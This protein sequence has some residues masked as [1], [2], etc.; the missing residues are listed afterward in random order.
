MDCKQII[1]IGMHH[2]GTSI[3]SRMTMNMGIYGG[4]I[5]TDFILSEQN[6]L[7]F[8]ERIDVVNENQE[9]FE[10]FEWR[11][12][13][14]SG[15][16]ERRHSGLPYWSGVTYKPNVGIP[17]HLRPSVQ[18]II[19]KLDTHCNWVTKDPRFGLLLHEWM[20]LLRNPIC[21]FIK[22]KKEETVTSLTRFANYPEKWS[23]LYDKYYN[24]SYNAC[25]SRN[26]PI[27]NMEHDQLINFPQNSL[28]TMY[29]FLHGLHVPLHPIHEIDI[30][31]QK[32]NE[33][34]VTLLTGPNIEYAKGARALLNSIHVLDKRRDII[35]LTTEDVPQSLIDDYLSL[36]YVIHKRITRIHEF[37]WNSCEYSSTSDKNT[38]WGLMMSKLHIWTLP[39]KRVL[40]LDPDS[41][42]LR[43][44][45][46][47]KGNDILMAQKGLNHPYFNAGVM[48]L[49]P[50]NQT[51]NDFMKMNDEKHPRLYNNVIDCTEQALLNSY[52]GN[53][54]NLDVVRPETDAENNDEGIAI[55][56]I[57]KWCPK[58]W[59]S[60]DINGC[61]IKFYNL[62]DKYYEMV[63]NKYYG[64]DK[65]KRWNSQSLRVAESQS[66]RVAEP[67]FKLL[68]FHLRK[69]C[70]Q[71]SWICNAYETIM[72]NHET[73]MQLFSFSKNHEYESINKEYDFQQKMQFDG[74]RRLQ[75]VRDREY[76]SYPRYNYDLNYIL[77]ICFLSTTLMGICFHYIWVH[78]L[79][80]Y[81]AHVDGFSVLG[82]GNEPDCAES[83]D[84]EK[85]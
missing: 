36:P 6:P 49:S 57:T 45:D 13:T 61:E 34:Y 3:L 25:L 51:F 21:I 10:E 27:L 79:S 76:E 68:L 83:E 42:L 72:K 40:Y 55:H 11:G 1:L 63:D 62:W 23:D 14:S 41:I 9:R 17:M 81:H 8:W 19:S 15:F 82:S 22:R 48:V 64:N 32:P 33:A 18:N 54:S 12:V 71:T 46:T 59:E 69:W 2:T 4:E 47:I 56:W 39:Y 26:A 28:K 24:E 58:P 77:I 31:F 50:S 67:M 74:G 84:E 60:A 16:V 20:P 85:K 7:K 29:S 66:R 73:T 53:V 52:F 70:K 37:W 38:R 35:C 44:L 5:P 80:S 78:M 43:T 75:T 30:P 65:I